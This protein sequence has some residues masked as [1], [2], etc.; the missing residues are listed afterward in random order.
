MD[1]LS[2]DIKMVKTFSKCS[3]LFSFLAENIVLGK[4]VFGVCPS[5]DFLKMTQHFGN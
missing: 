1:S 2:L 3:K 5:S 4:T